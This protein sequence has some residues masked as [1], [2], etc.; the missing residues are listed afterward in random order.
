MADG[1]PATTGRRDIIKKRQQLNTAITMAY[2]AESDYGTVPPDVRKA[3]RTATLAYAEELGEHQD[4]NVVEHDWPDED[5]AW[6]EALPRQTVTAYEPAPG[7]TTAQ[8]PTQEPALYSVDWRNILDIA[9]QLKKIGKDL[10]FSAEVG[11]Q[12]ADLDEAVV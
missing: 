11:M 1:P 9:R 6:L 5:L 12:E 10:G 2:D 8:I 3:L 7:D 4:E